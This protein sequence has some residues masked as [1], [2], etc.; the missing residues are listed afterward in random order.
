MRSEQHGAC[1]SLCVVVRIAYERQSFA[2]LQYNQGDAVVTDNNIAFFT[3]W[4]VH[5]GV[6]YLS[7]NHKADYFR[8][9][10]M[11][12]YGGGY[13]DIKRQVG[14]WQKYLAAFRDPMSRW[15]G[16]SKFLAE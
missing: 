10:F 12:Y 8:V 7:G 11:Y 3:K 15:W 16:C 4:Y 6:Q 1:D 13:A 5:P 2:S 14:S 9:Y